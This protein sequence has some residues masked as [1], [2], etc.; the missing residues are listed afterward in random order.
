M[1]IHTH[2]QYTKQGRE[3][4]G[5]GGR[6]RKRETDRKTPETRG[7][8][9]TCSILKLSSDSQLPC[10]KTSGHDGSYL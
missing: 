2:E 1:H 7:L 10:R 5:R 3:G 9:W 4:A 8:E 6:E